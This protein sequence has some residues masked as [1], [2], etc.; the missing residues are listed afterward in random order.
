MASAPRLA[1]C[2]ERDMRNGQRAILDLHDRASVGP[3]FSSK[4]VK[5]GMHVSNGYSV[6]VALR[7]VDVA[8]E[9]G[10]PERG[11]LDEG[12]SGCVG[13]SKSFC[14]IICYTCAPS[15]LR[16]GSSESMIS[17]GLLGCTQNMLI[18]S[19]K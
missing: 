5:F 10:V 17:T 13:P 16:V 6:G 19:F 14:C 12:L 15:R 4:I 7:G 18:K 3:L 2:S 1:F 11:R 9:C 8:G